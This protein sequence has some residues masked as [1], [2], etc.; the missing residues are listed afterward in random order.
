MCAP[1]SA[2][3]VPEP[4]HAS[5]SQRCISESRPVALDECPWRRRYLSTESPTSAK[6]VL[7]SCTHAGVGVCNGTYVLAMRVRTA[8]HDDG[9][10]ELIRC[11]GHLVRCRRAASRLLHAARL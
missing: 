2:K 5:R 8:L 11:R 10:P 6:P 4:G 7:R 1:V 3:S 9:S